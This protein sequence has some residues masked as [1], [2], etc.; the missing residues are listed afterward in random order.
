MNY[1]KKGQIPTNTALLTFDDGYY[2]IYK[3][4]YSFLKKNEI[5]F[6]IFPITKILENNYIKWDDRLTNYIFNTN[7]NIINTEI[8]GKTYSYKLNNRNDRKNCIIEIV[9]LLQKYN[10]NFIELYLTRLKKELNICDKRESIYLSWKEI[11]KL[12]KDPLV[13][14]GAHTHSHVNLTKIDIKVAEK[15]ILK[16]KKIIEEKIGKKCYIF[17]YP[18]GRKNDF[19]EDII[20]ILKKNKFKIALSTIPGRIN[21]KTNLYSINR[22]SVP[23]DASYKFKTSLV[24]I[25]LQRS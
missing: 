24:G 12:S 4:A 8:S 5:P 16:S 11:F 20:K 3:N 10:M 25:P 18:F 21:L 14:I 15:E 2:D 9:N 1:L 7:K 6:T 17:S 19:N 22:I 23:N 13:T